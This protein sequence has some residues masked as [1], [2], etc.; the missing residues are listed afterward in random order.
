MGGYLPLDLALDNNRY[1]LANGADIEARDQHGKGL[2]A[3]Q[4][5]ANGSYAV[6][7]RYLIESGANPNKAHPNNLWVCKEAAEYADGDKLDSED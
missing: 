1:D 4:H 2:S 5:A 6:N 3:L 7:V